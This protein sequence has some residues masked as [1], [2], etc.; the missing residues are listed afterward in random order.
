MYIK[1]PKFFEKLIVITEQYSIYSF[2][3]ENNN[4]QS[5]ELRSG[6]AIG[7]EERAAELFCK[8]SR[9]N[10]SKTVTLIDLKIAH[11]NSEPNQPC[12]QWLI[13]I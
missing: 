7:L 12:T 11:R 4:F 13:E 1:N 3:S 9:G 5:K 10:I 8:N 2:Q 6:G